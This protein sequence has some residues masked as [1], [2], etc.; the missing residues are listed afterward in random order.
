MHGTVEGVLT[1]AGYGREKIV[2]RTPKNFAIHSCTLL[3]EGG[4]GEGLSLQSHPSLVDQMRNGDVRS[5]GGGVEA[6]SSLTEQLQ[7]DRSER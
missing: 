6:P 7:G 5:L 3:G 2:L 4:K 1:A